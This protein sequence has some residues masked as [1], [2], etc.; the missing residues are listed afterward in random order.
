MLDK[1]NRLISKSENKESNKNLSYKT[2][3]I[4]ETKASR[5][6]AASITSPNGKLYFESVIIYFGTKET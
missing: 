3:A 1:N 2:T 6:R 5:L 4:R